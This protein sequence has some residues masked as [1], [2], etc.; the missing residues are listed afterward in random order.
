MSTK[1]SVTIY[2]QGHLLHH[3]QGETLLETLLRS[4]IELDFSCKSGVCHRCMLRCIEGDIPHDAA[5][6]LPSHQQETGCLLACQCRPTTDMMLAPK[7]PEDMVT[8]SMGVALED[9]PSSAWQ[10]TFE[11]LRTLN[12]QT[13]QL[14]ELMSD[15]MQDPVLATLMSNPDSDEY[16][17]AQTDP[18]ARLPSWLSR[19]S[20][21]GL[22]FCVR[23]PFP[24]EPVDQTVALPPD[25]QLWHQLGGDNVVRAVL[26]TFY[27]SVYQDPQLLPFFE[28][29][30]MD[31][32]IG[33]QFAFLK[34]NILGEQVFLGEQPRN[35]HNWMVI[36][37]ALFDHRQHLMLQAMRQHQLSESLIE[38]WS[39]YEEQFRRDIVKYKPWPKRFGDL[40]IDTEQYETCLLEEATVCDYCGDEIPA[41]TM[42]K[43]HKRIGKLGCERCSLTT[44]TL[45]ETAS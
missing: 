34:E 22:S 42:V 44:K 14:V 35:T 19:E 18:L 38:R 32:I 43:F 30:T 25:P 20:I 27:Q 23:G 28:R 5:R 8:R 45:T 2:Y 21:D 6:K 16:V 4:G 11:T 17:I 15:S 39:A 29:V 33:K 3:R 13:G 24:V 9:S 37:D 12:Y 7:S 26:T 36:N 31:R 41:N 40:V 1:D 10:L